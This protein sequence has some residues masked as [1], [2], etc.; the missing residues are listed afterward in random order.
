MRFRRRFLVAALCS[1]SASIFA[2]STFNAPAVKVDTD[3]VSIR[4][5]EVVFADSFKL[6][7]DRLRTGEVT[8]DNLLKEVQHAWTEAIDSATQDKIIDQLA[9]KNRKDIIKSIVAR[10]GPEVSSAQVVEWFNRWEA[11]E[12]RRL[13]RELVSVAGGEDELKA[14]LKRRGQTLEEWERGLSRELFRRNVLAMRLGPILSSPAAARAYYEKHPEQFHQEDAWQLR[15][16]RIPKAESSTAEI[17]LEKAKLVREKIN[18]GANFSDI[19]A[20]VSDDPQFAKQG[21]LLS[22]AGK[23]ELPSGTFPGEEKIAQGLKDGELSQPIDVGDWF[24]IVQRAGY[25]AASTQT[26]EQAAE[27][28]EGLSMQ[29]KLKEKKKELFDKLKRDAYIEVIQKDPPASVLKLANLDSK[30]APER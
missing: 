24:V 28:A 29:E 2:A 3:V 21:G 22:R 26:F 12:I 11:D 16:I 18:S 23:T 25:R 6:L 15:R 30:P 14:A 1:V 17:A 10:N 4:E 9:D 27:K 7:Q 20:K 8:Q 19:A 5:V 13:R